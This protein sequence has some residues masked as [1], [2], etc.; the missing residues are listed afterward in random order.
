MQALPWPCKAYFSAQSHGGSTPVCPRRARGW[1]PTTEART[2]SQHVS[3]KSQSS[4]VVLDFH[5]PSLLPQVGHS[6]PCISTLA[7]DWL[8]S[9]RRAPS[10]S[11]GSES[12]FQMEK[13]SPYGPRSQR[14]QAAGWATASWLDKARPHRALRAAA[15]RR[16]GCGHGPRRICRPWL[17]KERAA[18]GCCCLPHLPLH[19]AH[20]RRR[21]WHSFFKGIS[22]FIFPG[23]A[24]RGQKESASPA[25]LPPASDIPLWPSLGTDCHS[26][27]AH[28]YREQQ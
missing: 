27:T 18:P 11:L 7:Q 21:Q 23:P 16:P 13:P 10:L 28:T 9:E 22:C 20:S 6:E 15:G 25:G 12:V 17:N 1:P 3:V 19:P 5:P 14:H 8:Q 4:R 26:C 24:S 2:H